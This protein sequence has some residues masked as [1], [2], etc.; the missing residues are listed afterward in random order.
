MKIAANT[1]PNPDVASKGT[2]PTKTPKGQ[3]EAIRPPARAKGIDRTAPVYPKMRDCRR[4]V[5]CAFGFMDVVFEFVSVNKFR[6]GIAEKNS[7]TITHGV[8][9]FSALRS[10]INLIVQS[11]V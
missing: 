8:E 5:V 6:Y 2:A 4:M 1:D 10:G 3:H 11:D 9:D 7:P